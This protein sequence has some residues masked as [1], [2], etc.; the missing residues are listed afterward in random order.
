MKLPQW[1]TLE[2]VEVIHSF[3][4]RWALGFF[5][6]VVICDVLLQ[7]LE[8]SKKLV[9][10]V[11]WRQHELEMKVCGRVWRARW[12]AYSDAISLK[13]ILKKISLLGFGIAILL[14]I[15]ALPYSERID[16]LSNQELTSAQKQIAAS[17]ENAAGANE[18]ARTSDLSRVQLE[19][20]LAPR[21]L[22]EK[23]RTSIANSLRRFTPDFV[24]RE[25][26]VSS[27][28]IDAEG[29]VFALQVTD[30]LNRAGIKVE[31]VIGRMMPIGL[32]DPGLYVRG[33]ISDKDFIE[34]LVKGLNSHLDKPQAGGRVGFE[35]YRGEM[36]R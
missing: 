11:G 18:R 25:I 23:D 27:Y 32:P 24:N 28:I 5:A 26:K 35:V 36:L 30:I 6:G 21:T 10:D 16:A 1:D 13:R 8:E 29:G 4:E 33:P 12:P 14:E 9:W 2:A 17:L 7:F 20:R 31:P 34:T 22:D 15:I 19:K 3:L